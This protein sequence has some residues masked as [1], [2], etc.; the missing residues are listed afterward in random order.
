MQGEIR[1]GYQYALD[2]THHGHQH[3]VTFVNMGRGRPR[4]VIDAEWLQWALQRRSTSAIA[5]YLHLSR[6]T[7][8]SRMLELGLA[9]PQ[10]DPFIRIPIVEE[11]ER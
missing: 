11:E 4:A 2:H 7:V 1:Q 9:E 8:R 10:Q 6:A 5:D 3:P